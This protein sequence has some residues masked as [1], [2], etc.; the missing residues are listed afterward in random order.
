MCVAR[1]EH[2]NIGWIH[3][4]FYLLGKGGY[5]YGSVGSSVCL[6]VDNITQKIMND[7]DEI[8]QRGP[9]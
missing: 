3:C 9:G 2:L 4:I 7:W 1:S 6:S 5:V 8:L